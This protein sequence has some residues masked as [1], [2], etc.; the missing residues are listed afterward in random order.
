MRLPLTISSYISKEFLKN[1]STVFSIFFIILIMLNSLEVLRRSYGRDVSFLVYMK[2][3]LLKLPFLLKSIIPF[4]ILI[5]AVLCYSRLNRNFELV[6]LRSAS[7]SAWKFIMPTVLLALM[8]GV[9]N[10]TMFDPISAFLFKKHKMVE[11]KHIYGEDRILSISPNGIWL[12]D[13]GDRLEKIIH[14]QYLYNLGK[15]LSEV[16]VFKLTNNSKFTTRI[17]ADT[18]IIENGILHLT[19]A[20]VYEPGKK[21]QYFPIYD[22]ETNLAA[23]Q[24]K[25]N[26]PLPEIISFWGLPKF[27]KEI[28]AAGFNALEHKVYFYNLI[29]SPFFLAAIALLASSLTLRHPRTFRFGQVVVFSIFVGFLVYFFNRVIQVMTLSGNI[30]IWLGVITPTIACTLVGVYIVLRKEHG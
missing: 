25:E 12:K 2:V 13:Q 21:P 3:I 15:Y 11:S 24:V 23:E 29:A 20:Y 5:G 16:V 9:F 28:E 8:I 17:N 10:I 18:A 26:V 30:P 22:M 6:V 7:L 19:D 1:T 14:A 27:I 4:A